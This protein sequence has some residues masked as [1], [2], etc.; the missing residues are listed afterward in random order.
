MAT[1]DEEVSSRRPP[2][3]VARERRVELETCAFCPRLCRAAC[4]VSNAE[5][6]EALTP[7]GKMTSLLS[8]E[9][10]ASNLLAFACTG[11]GAC[12]TACRH[13]NPVAEVLI[14]GRASLADAG[15]APAVAERVAR[16]HPSRVLRQSALVSR[17]RADP[18]ARADATTSLLLGCP[19]LRGPAESAE[20]M[21]HIAAELAGE[22]VRVLSECCGVVPTL[23]GDPSG[24]ERAR[25][26]LARELAGT[27]R[28]VVADPGCMRGVLP[29]GEPLAGSLEPLSLLAWA[30][31]NAASLVRVAEPGARYGFQMPCWARG[32]AA[33]PAAL[34]LLERL[35]GSFET[36]GSGCSGGGS[37]LPVTYPDTS[38]AIADGR[39]AQFAERGVTKLVTGCASGARRLRAAGDAT[40]PEVIELTTLI[41]EGLGRP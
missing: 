40:T 37:L 4:P 15:R 24:A 18:A 34:V 29:D 7:F 14:E 36:L 31:G 12:T 8:P 10:D 11:C 38:K 16:E 5:P 25:E 3:S 6:R 30:A 28:L 22:P 26:K 33:E 32:T 17:L 9:R 39:L 41:W 21:L 23:A 35:V 2:L 1:F 19:V 27:R 13:E 20:R